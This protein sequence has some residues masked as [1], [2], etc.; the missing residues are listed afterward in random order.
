[1]NKREVLT[2]G[3]PDIPLDL[4]EYLETVWDPRC[5]MPNESVE[6]HLRYAGAV[7]LVTLMRAAV[8]A[9]LAR[10]GD[11]ETDTREIT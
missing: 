10:S 11:N 4:L 6:E 8:N 9:K 3:W 7:G 1:M 2:K 5:M